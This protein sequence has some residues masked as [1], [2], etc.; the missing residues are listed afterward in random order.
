MTHPIEQSST[1]NG[2]PSGRRLGACAVLLAVA[3]SML[4]AIGAAQ[5]ET[6]LTVVGVAT[7]PVALGLILAWRAALLTYWQ[8][9]EPT[10]RSPQ[11]R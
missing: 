10:G 2:P 3:S 9:R 5:G 11:L 1:G 7:A 8:Q 6:F 4:I